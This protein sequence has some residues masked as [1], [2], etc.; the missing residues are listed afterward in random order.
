MHELATNSMKYGALSATTGTLDVSCA[1]KDDE[2]A[3]VWTE[4][5]GP[6][7]VAPSE[8]GGFGGTLLK[9]SMVD[10]L[11]GS[12]EHNWSEDGAIIT[13]RMDKRRLAH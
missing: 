2:V 7:V 12:V 5:G 11:N 10:Q 4:R 6:L 8:L 1:A 3:L 9:R 13:L